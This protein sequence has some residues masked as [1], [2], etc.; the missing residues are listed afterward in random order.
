[1][2]AVAQTNDHM[3]TVYDALRRELVDVLTERHSQGRLD[4]VTALAA[5]APRP[6]DLAR[7]I[8]DIL[9]AVHPQ[10]DAKA[11]ALV[12]ADAEFIA[13]TLLR[14]GNERQCGAGQLLWP[15]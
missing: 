8:A 5:R 7:S 6:I 15:T 13:N 11:Y 9:I 2:E 4:P 12:R 14:E 10:K 1:V 3:G